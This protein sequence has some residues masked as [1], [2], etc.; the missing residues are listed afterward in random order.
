[1]KIEK[2][3][4]GRLSRVEKTLSIFFT[5]QKKRRAFV[6]F[7]HSQMRGYH[8]ELRPNFITE[9]RKVNNYI[10]VF[11]SGTSVTSKYAI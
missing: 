8:F 1:M 9:H 10:K 2:G 11:K 3:A 7:Q 4:P 5:L 6:S